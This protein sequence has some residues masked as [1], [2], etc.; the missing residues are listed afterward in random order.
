MKL[1]GIYRPDVYMIGARGEEKP[2]DGSTKF[3]N[4]M[5]VPA[6]L[7]YVAPFIGVIFAQFNGSSDA[8]R[9]AAIFPMIYHFYSAFGALFLFNDALNPK[10]ISVSGSFG[11][12]FIFGILCYGLYHFASDTPKKLKQ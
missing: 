5:R 6:G 4:L 3:E 1:P 10:V 9:T 7:C 12:H 11:M 8:K 2:G